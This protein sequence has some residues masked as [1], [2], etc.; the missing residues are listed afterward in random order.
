MRLVLSHADS[1]RWA[2]SPADAWQ[3]EETI[4]QW[5]VD[6]NVDEPVVVVLASGE[7]AFAFC[8]GGDA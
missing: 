1:V 5:A 6:T 2:S 4:L 8:V 3:V 7:N